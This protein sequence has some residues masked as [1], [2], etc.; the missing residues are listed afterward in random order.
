M[1]VVRDTTIA[2][3]V[4]VFVAAIAVVLYAIAAMLP[5]WVAAA[6]LVAAVAAGITLDRACPPGWPKDHDG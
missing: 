6:G 3:L 4:I 2:V 1:P 5:R